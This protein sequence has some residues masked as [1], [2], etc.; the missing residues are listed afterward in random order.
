MVKAGLPV[1][2]PDYIAPEVLQC[3]DNKNEKVTSYG[4]S[5]D[6]WSMGILAYELMVGTPP[7]QGHNSTTIY[8]KIINYFKNLKFPPDIT[9]SQGYVTFVKSLITD[10]KSRLKADQIKNHV[11]F[12]DV[13]F[14]T[15]RD[16]VPPHVPKINSMDDT[17][18]FTDIQGKKKH[19]SMENFKRRTQFSGKGL[20]FIGFTFTPDPSGT[21]DT[22]LKRHSN[23]KNDLVENLRA[24]VADLKMALSKS[25][26][27]NQ[28]KDHLEKKLDETTIKIQGLE[29]LRDKLE[30]QLAE[31]IAES[32][33]VK[34]ILDVERKERVNLEKRALDLIKGA[35]L[36]WEQAEKGKVEGLNLEIKQLTSK[37]EQLINTNR[38]LEEQLQHAM[39][40]EETNK[41]SLETEKNFNR[42]SMVGLENLLEKVTSN[43]QNK[44]SELQSKLNDETSNNLKL[45]NTVDQL[46]NALEKTESELVMAKDRCEKSRW[47]HDQLEI[48][49]LEN[50]T[51]IKQLSEKL[52][53]LENDLE[54]L[55]AYEREIMELKC[56]IDDG[57]KSI[58]ELQNKIVLLQNE[59][60]S[61]N[62]IKQENAEFKE[63]NGEMHLKI[64][65]LEKELEQKKEH[66][67]ALKNRLIEEESVETKTQELREKQLQYYKIQKDLSNCQID[68]R[69]LE[70][71]LKDAKAEIKLLETKVADL[72][73]TISENKQSNELALLELSGINESISIEL[74]KANETIKNL[75]DQLLNEKSKTDD[76]KTII[77]ELKGF[78]SSKEDTIKVLEKQLKDL[79]LHLSNKESIFK[80]EE[81]E[82]SKLM[83]LIE[84]LQKE[85]EGF[86][87]T[88]DKLSVEKSNMKLNLDALREACTL[89][90][91]QVIEYEKLVEMS[92]SKQS[93]L[94]ANT[95]KLIADLCEARRETQEARRHINE[96]KSLRAMSEAKI[97]RLQEDIKCLEREC[98]DYKSQYMEYKQFSSRFSEELTASEEKLSNAEVLIKSYERQ[99][100]KLSSENN[101]LKEETSDYI[102]KIAH[103]KEA[104][105]KLTHQVEDFNKNVKILTQRIND[106][107]EV[108]NEKM[109]YYKEREVKAEARDKQHLKL[110]DYLQSKIEEQ[111]NKKKSI[112]QVIFGS[113]KKENQPPISLALNYKDMESEL[114]KEREINRKLKEE[115]FKLKA[116]TLVDINNDIMEKMKIMEKSESGILTQQAKVPCKNSY[117]QRHNIP[118]RLE[119]KLSTTAQKCVQCNNQIM[120]GRNHRVCKDCKVVVHVHC[121]SGLPN[122]CGFP[123]EFATHFNENIKEV[124]KEAMPEAIFEGWIKTPCNGKWEK[125]YARVTETSLDIYTLQPSIEGSE[126]PVQKFPLKCEGFY[127]KVVLEPLQS[128]ID[129]PVVQ[130]DLPFVMK[131]EL[132]SEN[133][134]Q[135]SNTFILMA[136]SAKDKDCWFEALK[137]HFATDKLDT[138]LV[139]VMKLPDNL[140]VNCIVEL[141]ENI[142]V[143]GT[144]TGFY[145]YYEDNLKYI[146]G[147]SKVKQIAIFEVAQSM[148]LIQGSKSTLISCD[149]NHVI[150]LAQCASFTKPTLKYQHLDVNNLSEFHILQISKHSNQKKAAVATPKQLIILE[151]FIETNEFLA[152]RILDTAQPTSCLLFTENS[153]IVG[154]DKFFEIDLNTFQAE[155]FLDASDVQLKQALKCYKIGS[156]PLA[157]LQIST[158]PKE[159]LLC[160]NE[161]SIFVDEYGRTSRSKEIKNDH[162]SLKLLKNYV[163]QA[164]L[165]LIDW[166]WPSLNT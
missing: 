166:D 154:A 80:K 36:K 102:T 152:V 105:Y 150:N 161:F 106:I 94:T 76:E 22:S 77:K 66:C 71:E 112:T 135:S 15:I 110:I 124:K 157:I 60:H 156:F 4:V 19:P 52:N 42:R 30:K 43:K 65:T 153:L 55:D 35:K 67:K 25:G 59:C 61:F 137:K 108:Y 6:F 38:I 90:E 162:K 126:S 50:E 134:C 125:R 54:K 142:M 72:E 91:G 132:S 139:P 40:I 115:V 44:I 117:S 98:A 3:L 121:V 103:L 122:L 20:P 48:K 28:E 81:I 14:E 31:S 13:N 83:T 34:R 27:F 100:E 82:K 155:E 57:Q 63:K 1:G 62:Q 26:D 18:N 95:E 101:L 129:V 160:F 78:L 79:K 49:F 138:K 70:R 23:Q 10:V 87:D 149:L 123:K 97:K 45:R 159:Y 146:D 147:L 16:R 104:K 96:E 21:F 74:V 140:V 145:S 151:Y 2:T 86:Q 120:L 127:G 5:C 136:L 56:Q 47:E 163:P 92:K 111:N 51:V 116:T 89:L 9:L 69:I 164:R 37:M 64:S 73:K 24:E 75:K 53:D 148:L 113:S 99:I 88:I 39:K 114:I 119:T 11:I 12:K 85:K 144:D 141:T 46:Q 109:N 7:F 29:G 84:Q 158:N 68:K 107:E 131:L 41:K 133:T 118:H 143:L 32:T 128:E 93:E 130:N 58:K 17:S 8:S 165:S 33:A